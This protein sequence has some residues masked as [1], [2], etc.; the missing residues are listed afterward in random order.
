[1]ATHE[2]HLLVRV[3]RSIRGASQEEMGAA[4]SIDRTTISRYET[5]DMSPSRSHLTRLA[6]AAG[7][8]LPFVESVLQPAVRLV[9]TPAASPSRA[10]FSHAGGGPAATEQA[11]MDTVRSGIAVFLADLMARGAGSRQV[12]PT[13]NERLNVPPLWARFQSSGSCEQRRRLIE[14]A[15]ELQTWAFSER[16]C[17]ESERVA[18]ENAEQA[19]ELAQLGLQA[20]ERSPGDAGWKARLQAYAW[21]FI[22]NALRVQGDL[23]AADAAFAMTRTL[24]GESTPGYAGLLA[25]WRPLDLEASL[26]RDQRNWAAASSLLDRAR[27]IAPP[28]A[29]GRILIKKATVLERAGDLPAALATLDEAEQRL[30][31]TA[32][33]RLRWVTQFNRL[34]CFCHLGRYQEAAA[35]L[36]A[37][38]ETAT[39]LGHD[40]DM[41]RS[42]WL[43][44]RVAAN[45][46]RRQQAIVSFEQ[47]RAEFVAR[48]NTYLTAAVSLELAIVYLEEGRFGEVRQLAGSMVCIFESQQVHRET[49][50]SLRLFCKASEATTATAEQIRHLLSCL[51]RA[52]QDPQLVFERSLLG[53]T[54]E[55]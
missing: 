36:Q 10:R 42:L 16:L 40:L 15:P 25:E 46:G 28:E 51:E 37:V 24:W 32:E 13:S 7:L 3:L 38:T 1:V 54:G 9:L 11:M 20:G 52:R 26:R 43:K 47:V 39:A 27:Q 2:V 19:L 30:G 5:G 14:V 48:R 23:P 4:A 50:A 6:A 44:G 17:E 8:S 33:P 12:L 55:P 45:Q 34:V 29:V 35:Q 53:W 22:G 18:A 49:L 31:A 41:V 21:A